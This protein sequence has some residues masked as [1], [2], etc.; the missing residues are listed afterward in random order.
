GP[1]RQ[2]E[3]AHALAPVLL[4]IVERPEL[5]PLALRVPAVIAVAKAEHAFLRPALLLVAA[6]PAER[7]VEAVL[8]ERLLEAF[9][10]PHVGVQRAVIERVDAAADGFRI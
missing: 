4:H 2:G 3:D 8:V 5:G 6:R 1:V 10:L 9:R 7:G